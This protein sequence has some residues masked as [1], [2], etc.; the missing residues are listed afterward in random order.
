L[1]YACVPQP[2]YVV[3]PLHHDELQ[4]EIEAQHTS[5][6]I[7]QRALHD[8]DDDDDNYISMAMPVKASPRS[9]LSTENI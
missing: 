9:A 5:T 8:D 2:R 4:S 7:Q 6:R 1:G 3:L